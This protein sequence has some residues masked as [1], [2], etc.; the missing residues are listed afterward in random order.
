MEKAKSRGLL[1]YS[2]ILTL[3]FAPGWMRLALPDRPL[4][5]GARER[6]TEAGIQSEQASPAREEKSDCDDCVI[7]LRGDRELMAGWVAGPRTKT[8][9]LRD[10]DGKLV[11]DP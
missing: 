5:H 4:P 6:V 7:V 1:A 3:V 2:A 8:C 11:C 9:R 10:I